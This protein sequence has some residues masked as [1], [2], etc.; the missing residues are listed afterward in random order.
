MALRLAVVADAAAREQDQRH[1]AVAQA[2]RAGQRPASVAG[3]TGA[4]ALVAAGSTAG[5][6]AVLVE[7]RAGAAA[8]RAGATAVVAV[9]ARTG[10]VELPRFDALEEVDALRAAQGDGRLRQVQAHGGLQQVAQ[11]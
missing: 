2:D 8:A 5:A 11:M 3:R 1:L 6:R 7:K 10:G 9:V 4:I